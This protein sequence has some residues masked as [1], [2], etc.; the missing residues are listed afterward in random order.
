[1]KEIMNLLCLS[2]K[3]DPASLIPVITLHVL[4]CIVENI[5]PHNTEH[6]QIFDVAAYG[7]LTFILCED[8]ADINAQTWYSKVTTENLKF[9]A[10]GAY[11]LPKR[12]D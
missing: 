2:D 3:H 11:A 9:L 12:N 8:V 1:M 10:L 6:L 5:D 7:I 4:R